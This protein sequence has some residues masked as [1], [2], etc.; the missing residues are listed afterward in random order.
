[1]SDARIPDQPAERP[2]L[3]VHDLEVRFAVKR[4]G[5]FNKPAQLHAVDGVS[6]QIGAGRTLGLVGESGS[7]KSTTA[8]AAAKLVPA[9]SGRVEID[10]TDILALEGEALR[11]QRRNVQFIFQDPYSSLNPRLRASEIV[12]E[13]L[14]RLNVDSRAER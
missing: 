7:G 2:T 9:R 6:F 13:P 1:M 11:Q 12:R 8:L 4:E 14:D 3:S 10:G 5:L